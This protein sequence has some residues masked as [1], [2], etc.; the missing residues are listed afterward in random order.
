MTQSRPTVRLLSGT[1]C[2]AFLALAGCANVSVPGYGSLDTLSPSG[3][4]A[5]PTTARPEPDARGVISYPNYQ[6]AVARPGDTVNG[7]AGRLGIS[8]NDLARTNGL[9]VDAALRSG[10]LVLL[11]TRVAEAPGSNTLNSGSVSVETLAGD[12]LNRASGT[13]TTTASPTTPSSTEPVRHRVASGETAYSIARSYNVSPQAL[14]QWNGLD[15]SLSVREGQVL[16]IPTAAGPAPAVNSDTTPGQGTPTP[17]PPSADAPQPA[18]NPAPA[19]EAT[20]QKTQPVADLSGQQTAA[21]DSARLLQPV[22]GRII[23]GYEPKKNEGLDFAAN[24][25]TNVRAADGGTVAAIT[26]DTD[27][28]PILVLRHSDNL[29]TVY[30]NLDGITVKKGDS[31]SRGQTIGKVSSGNNSTLHFEVR[32]GFEAVDPM[33]YL[34]N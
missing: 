20:A 27:Q 1:A 8:G 17:V 16:L 18:E 29:L 21:S 24:P 32:K 25:G 22:G 15:S 13:G 26:R 34:T 6:V 9:P 33:P 3:Q 5:V 11:P 4:P 31:V 12:A 30:A 28:V 19:S 23:R 14:A 10:E 7:I 2:V